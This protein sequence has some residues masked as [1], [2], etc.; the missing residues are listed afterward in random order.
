MFKVDQSMLKQVFCFGSK[1]LTSSWIALINFPLDL[2]NA[3]PS[4]CVHTN[5]VYGLRRGL[6]GAIK[7]FNCP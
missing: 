2:L 3:L 4:S 1:I 5:C 6:N 7:S